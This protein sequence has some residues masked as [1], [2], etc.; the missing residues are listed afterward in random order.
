[1]TVVSGRGA[2]LGDVSFGHRDLVSGNEPGDAG[3]YH[4]DPRSVS[5]EDVRDF[6]T[7]DGGA[8][9]IKGRL[10]RCAWDEP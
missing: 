1:M 6:G 9:D 8:R 2:D 10:L 5:R 3:V 7:P 4:D